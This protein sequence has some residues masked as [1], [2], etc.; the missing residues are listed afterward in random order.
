MEL[1]IVCTRSRRKFS[2]KELNVEKLECDMHQ[3]DKVGASTV[4][5][6]TGIKDKVTSHSHCI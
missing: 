5:G 6:L 1:F 2:S 4:G 3:G